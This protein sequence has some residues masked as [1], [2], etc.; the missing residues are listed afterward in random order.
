M[1]AKRNRADDHAV[2][3]RINGLIAEERMLYEL[4][5]LS[6]EDLERLEKI[7]VQLDQC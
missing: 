3:D 7:K 4:P 1:K 2:L 6:E 5:A